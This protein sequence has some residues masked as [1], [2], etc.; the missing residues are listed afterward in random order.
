MR[1]TAPLLLLATMSLPAFAATDNAC[2]MRDTER[3][4]FY[5][6]PP[7]RGDN[8]FFM[9]I[10]SGQP[11]VNMIFQGTASMV[12]LPVSL[13]ELKG[14]NDANGRNALNTSPNS[15]FDTTKFTTPLTFP[16]PGNTAVCATV[17]SC[18]CSNTFLNNLNYFMPDTIAP[19]AGASNLQGKYDPTKLYPEPETTYSGGNG[20]AWGF[21]AS[22]VN[23][24]NTD[25]TGGL[26]WRFKLWPAGAT[27]GT[28]TGTNNSIDDN[29]SAATGSGTTLP[30]NATDL[31]DC[32]AC[33]RTKGYWL[34]Y[35]T[36]IASGVVVND[37]TAAAGV[38]KGNWLNFY[39][40]KWGM[41]RLAY[42]RLM[43][44]PL[45]QPIREGIGT[46][47][48][49]A[50]GTPDGK[51]WY[52]L[53]KMLPQSCSGGGAGSAGITKQKVT[54]AD[55]V[56]FVSTYNPLAEELFNVDWTMS[57]YTSGSTTPPSTWG[58]FTDQSTHPVSEQGTSSDA[59]KKSG[60]CTG[61]NAGFV[62]M[63]SD[64]RG[65]DGLAT[66]DSAN[67]GNDPSKLP[68]F[69]S[70]AATADSHNACSGSTGT[71]PGK[72][73]GGEGDGDDFLDPNVS[74]GA[75]AAISKTNATYYTPSVSGVGPY[76]PNDFLPSV[77]AWEFATDLGSNSTDPTQDKPSTNMRLYT[78]GIGDNFFGEL[79]SIQGAAKA[80]HGLYLAATDFATLEN[81]ITNIFLDILS[82]ATSFSVA[83]ITTV[84]T[85]GTTFAFIPRF[86]PLGGPQWEGRLYRFRLFNEF[87]AGCGPSDLNPLGAADAG[88]FGLADG[89]RSPLNPN[90]NNSCTDLYLVD[91]DGG[92]VGEDDGGTFILLDPS[93][94]WNGD[95]GGWPPQ[96]DGGAH[97]PA[98][99]IW[100]AASVLAAREAKS[101]ADA[102]PARVILALGLDA[103]IPD[104]G[105]TDLVT[106]N[107]FSSANVATM[108]DYMKLSGV[109]SDFCTALG[110]ITRT[111][112]ATEQQCGSD[113]MKFIEG[114]DVMH[115]STD[116]GTVRPNIL[117]DIFHSSPILVT[118][119]VPV[120][121]CETGVVNQCVRTLYAEDTGGGTSGFT[122]D[123]GSAY[124]TYFTDNFQRPEIVL[125]GANDGMLHAFKA[126]TYNGDG[127]VNSISFDDG[128]G[129]ELW[130]FIPPDMVPKLQRYAVSQ[131]HNILVDG[132][133]WV[134][135]IWADGSGT[136][137]TTVDHAKEHDEF[138]TIAIIGERTGG[139][140]YVALDIT[141]TAHSPKFLWMWPRPGDNYDLA[142]GE[143]WNDTTPN[144][145]PIGPVLIA[146]NSGPIT[147]G[148]QKASERWVVAIAGGYDPNLV[149]GRAV[150]ILDA[151][152][153]QL[154][155][156][157][158]RYQT[159]P[160][161]AENVLG[162]VAAPVS[163]IDTNFDN[164]FDLATFGDT[165][166]NIFAIDMIKPGDISTGLS[167]T[168][169]GGTTFTQ[170]SGGA[171]SQRAPFFTMAGARIM[172]SSDPLST[173][174][175]LGGGDRDQIKVRD[176]D[177]VDGGTCVVDNL[178]GCIRNNCGVEV[179]QSVYSIG[180]DGTIEQFTA[181]W[182]YGASGTTMVPNSFSLGSNSQT[183]GV[184]TDPANV[185]TS[186]TISGCSSNWGDAGATVNNTLK[187]DF[188]GGSDGGEECP[189]TTGKPTDENAQFT[190]PAIKNTRFYS[191]KVFG[192]GR[193]R[194]TDIGSQ[195]SYTSSAMTDTDLTD[196]TDGGVMSTDAGGWFVRHMNDSNEKTA[197]AALVL[198][199]CVAWNTEVP[200]VIFGGSVGDG[201]VCSAGF[202][203]PPDTA[204]L[205]QANDDTGGIQCGLPGSNTQL[206]TVRYQARTVTVTPQ[207]LTPVVSLNAQTGQAAYSGVS[208]EP[209]G[210]IPLQISVGTAGVQGDV[211]WLDVSRN[212]H[213]CR[214]AT[215]VGADGGV[216]AS[217]Q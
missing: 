113:L 206:A 15:P 23:S 70:R 38:F 150:Y 18:G 183:A 13:Y 90:E 24:A 151:W 80:G 187:C 189:D 99:P 85:R 163:L 130:A 182:K 174:I 69:C 160:N 21:E 92:F 212:L 188:D 181:D 62:V 100:E 49:C 75:G 105:R 158:T 145:P 196:V 167:T 63:F 64:G 154:L 211:A 106:F 171:V 125:V 121:L 161:T 3:I 201:G 217:C 66:C 93:Q 103:G 178:R 30:Y 19:P 172:N 45:L 166:G 61:C 44:G 114:Q 215:T 123:G 173:R 76:C 143:S 102:G 48:N 56:T 82:N 28:N 141:D 7:S 9:S 213:N 134:R 16:V 101:I 124:N 2:W 65:H 162:P 108:T 29:C 116:G 192:K 209:G 118:P 31:A 120:A 67:Y 132:S 216:Q 17:G 175:Y 95:A 39:P 26:A 41:L 81:N 214:H 77:A 157:F 96:V 35:K 22:S 169:F 165:D 176:T 133:P 128:N 170:F 153:G 185:T 136:T 117:G 8:N 58:F 135:D 34:N 204:Y 47:S 73:L 148:N 137:S 126:G 202:G 109:N 71:T 110:S 127:G 198:G 159:S 184:C 115:Q 50:G 52:R 147:I 199:G 79:N 138:H 140:H 190:S 122:P 12:G 1:I 10:A 37:Q 60:F 164:Y 5:T 186:Y 33:V 210:K 51:G 42:K 88:F 83:A 97:V 32:K 11:A 156:K 197:S 149:R 98:V 94:P 89:G 112:Y 131:S 139:R 168:W 111:G 200:S 46:C 205:Y 91:A 104:G 53:Q 14:G 40:P 207:Q 55:A 144:P 179:N 4:D 78:V 68:Q 20:S 208:L 152:N 86:R 72:G 59:N 193:A 146:D 195:S 142:E 177:A 43:N 27:A 84:Q 54:A 194:M 129:D 57:S 36:T 87:A 203:I 107:D 180:S 191:L 119:P 6:N 74:G 25:K 155:F